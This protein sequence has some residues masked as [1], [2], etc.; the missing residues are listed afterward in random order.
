MASMEAFLWCS[1]VDIRFATP[2]SAAVEEAVPAVVGPND[3][4]LI[5]VLLIIAE[6]LDKIVIA[7]GFGLDI[8]CSL[9]ISD[10]NERLIPPSVSKLLILLAVVVSTIL[11]PFD[12]GN[13]P[14]FSIFNIS[15]WVLF[16]GLFF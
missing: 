15:D 8:D 11:S 16:F 13:F 10:C 4:V 5:E 1:S 6:S 7:V 2:L 9:R 14:A 12:E 3:V